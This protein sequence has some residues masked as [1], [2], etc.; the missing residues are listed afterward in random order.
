MELPEL[1]ERLV[2]A[3]DVDDL[4]AA[5]RL[6]KEL[7]PWF[8]VV[9]VGLELYT[10]CGPDALASFGDKGFQVFLDIKLHDIPTTVR[11]ASRVIGGL[12]VRYVTFHAQG[13]P[14]MLRAG[15]ERLAGG[16]EAV[17]VQ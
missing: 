4:V 8:G 2:L 16:A 3:L 12:G 17:R 15:G 9:K 10:A 11:K 1:R 5:G 13:G 6:A 14:G 7:Q